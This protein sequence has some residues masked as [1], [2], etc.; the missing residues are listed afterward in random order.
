MDEKHKG[1]ISRRLFVARAG[2]GAA[3]GAGCLRF[4][5]REA[6][7]AAQAAGKPLLTEESVNSFLAAKAERE[8]E[9]RRTLS[10]AQEN[11]QEFV[12]SHFYLTQQQEAA[13]DSITQE[14]VN[15]VRQALQ[16]A[17]GKHYK[18]EVRFVTDSQ[19]RNFSIQQTILEFSQNPPPPPHGGQGAKPGQ[20][21]VTVTN[22]DVNV[23]LGIVSVTVHCHHES[24]TK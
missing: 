9:F 7:A 23:N 21:K 12:R 10:E 14:Q 5:L 22:V 24:T 2:V 11:L 16:E 18:V 15:K 1:R 17:V 13:L 6:L 8:P 19:T 3:V 4:G 20:G